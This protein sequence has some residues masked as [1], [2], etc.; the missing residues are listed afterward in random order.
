MEHGKLGFCLYHYQKRSSLF[1]LV[2]L[3]KISSSWKVLFLGCSGY[4]CRCLGFLLGA[5]IDELK[6]CSVEPCT[7]MLLF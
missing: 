4:R 3:A 1:L 7:K 2:I 6:K 5:L